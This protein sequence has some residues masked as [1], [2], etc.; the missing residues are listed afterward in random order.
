MQATATL[1]LRHALALL[2]AA[3]A[4]AMAAPLLQLSS[5]LYTAFDLGIY[6]DELGAALAL[7]LLASVVAAALET[8]LPPRGAALV[9]AGVLAFQMIAILHIARTAWIV[10]PGLSREAKLSFVAAALAAACALA[11]RLDAA[12]L[13][14]LSEALLLFTVLAFALHPGML[15]YM[16][17]HPLRT[18]Q[19][20]SRVST[21]AVMG[22]T[23]RPR[24]VVLLI[25]DELDSELALREGFF[26]TPP[27][28]SLVERG[29]LSLQMQA[30]G[31]STLRSVPSMLAG[32]RLGDID[33]SGPGHLITRDGERWDRSSPSL[34]HDLEAA[35]TSYSVVGFYHDYCLIAPNPVSCYA[36]PVHAFPGWISSVKRSLRAETDFQNVYTGFMRQWSDLLKRLTDEAMFAVEHRQADF[37]WLHLNLP[38][39]PVGGNQRPRSLREDYAANLALSATFVGR[40]DAALREASDDYVL[41][42]TSDHWLRE[43]ELWHALYSA[44]LDA[45][46]ASAGKTSGR[47]DVPLL[48]G[49]GKAAPGSGVKLGSTDATDLRMLL[50]DLSSRKL[51]SP[52]E[53]A[54][55]MDGKRPPR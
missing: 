45:S 49:F 15:Q 16:L 19:A 36:R 47:H 30:G 48:I 54:D 51:N 55:W 23:G 39:P 5:S 40:L 11:L 1:T 33:H 52:A 41:V 8:H 34:F 46:A 22:A 2:T 14:R 12:R 13:R 3:A 7:C 17:D 42:I 53:V 38:H 20:P 18:A 10:A 31:P 6:G 26:N 25:L 21:G 4:L 44:R 50:L 28:R 35:G 32:R 29:A 43:H 9:R 27:L 37:V 24:P